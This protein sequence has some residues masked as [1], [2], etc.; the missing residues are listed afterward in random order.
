MIFVYI[1]AGLIATLLI[2]SAILPKVFNVE[3]TII[4][5]VYNIEELE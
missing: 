2:I 1:F 3:K 4:I 5:K